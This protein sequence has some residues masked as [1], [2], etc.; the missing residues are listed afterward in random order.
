MPD[1]D[2][3]ELA[4]LL[5]QET[6]SEGTPIMFVTSEATE[7]TYM[8]RGYRMGAVDFMVS[9]PVQGEILLQKAKVFVQMF[10]KRQELQVLVDSVQ[11]ENQ[12][13]HSRLE[14]FIREQETLRQAATH[15]PLT[16]LP[17]R[18]LLRDRLHAA[19]ARA[20]R[21]RQRFALA[22]VDLDGFKKVNDQHGHGTGDALIVAVA[23]KLAKAVRATDTVARLGGD[24]FALLFEG[25]DSPAGA[26]HVADKIHGLICEPVRLRSE[27]Q[28]QEVEVTVG[29][30]IGL[31]LFP[32][33]GS[34]V[35]DLVVLADMTMYAVKRDGGGA[36]V[37]SAPAG[38]KAEPHLV[39]VRKKDA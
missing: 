2:G 16:H 25:L 18:T 17:N 23:G 33:H 38:A 11:R 7:R 20:G 29:A 4:S 15:D 27:A 24:E 31:A 13:L 28:R 8:I 22:Y 21:N 36:R 34:E 19:R 10:R 6:R 14:V 35:D 30:S 32:D 3:F 37:C 26:Q 5:R 39:L 12:D 9:A 1:I